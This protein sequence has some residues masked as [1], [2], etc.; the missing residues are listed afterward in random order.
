MKYLNKCK[1]FTI[2]V[3][4][5]LVGCATVTPIRDFAST[6]NPSASKI[7]ISSINDTNMFNRN[8][9]LPGKIYINSVFYGEFSDNQREFSAE[10]LAG[11]NLVVI[12][13][14]HQQQCINAQI[15][16][17]PNKNY[18]YRYTL[19]QEYRVLWLNY[20]WKLIPIGVEDYFPNANI[21][22]PAGLSNKAL[23]VD[24]NTQTRNISNSPQIQPVDKTVTDV[25]LKMEA[26]KARC[27]ALGFQVGTQSFGECIL[28]LS[29]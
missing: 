25:E 19:V 16:V 17:L 18:K 23:P 3:T 21:N 24:S 7:S 5:F 8:A 27:S 14:Q 9:V 22:S 26:G 1:F 4:V 6:G 29:K 11:T 2:V 12:C 15:N 10:V 20:I 13:P 28:R